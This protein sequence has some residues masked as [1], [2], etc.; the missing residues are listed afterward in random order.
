MNYISIFTLQK[1]QLGDRDQCR[2]RA[3][4]KLATRLVQAARS[5]KLDDDS[6]RQ[7]VTSLKKKYEE[8]IMLLEE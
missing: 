8:E 2:Q 6:L 3:V 4:F 1:S 5:S 7:Y